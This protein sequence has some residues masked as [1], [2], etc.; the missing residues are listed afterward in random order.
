MGNDMTPRRTGPGDRRRGMIVRFVRDFGQVEGH[1]PSLRQIGDAVGLAVSTVS[2]HVAVL[3]Q[4]GTLRRGPRQPRT[5]VQ[6]V[7][8]G[9]TPAPGDDEV[10]VPLLGQIPAGFPVEAVELAEDTFRLP[11]RLVGHGTLFM[12]KVRGD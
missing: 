10:D 3:E 1:P 11:R 12:L 6:P 2:Y 8:P 5:L 9:P 4:E 7:S